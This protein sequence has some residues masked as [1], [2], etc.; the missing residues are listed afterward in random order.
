MSGLGVRVMGE[1][2][3]VANPVRCRG[4]AQGAVVDHTD[5]CFLSVC[6]YWNVLEEGTGE[7][8]KEI[9]PHTVGGRGLGTQ[10]EVL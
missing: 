9:L 8:G 6:R 7:Q 3:M 5:Q 2:R 10:L 1:E 4:R